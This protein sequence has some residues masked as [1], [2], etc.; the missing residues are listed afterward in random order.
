MTKLIA[1]IDNSKFIIK[2]CENN[3]KHYKA[4]IAIYVENEEYPLI[5]YI[6]LSTCDY[7]YKHGLDKEWKSFKEYTCILIHECKLR[8]ID[9][10]NECN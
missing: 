8:M 2:I 9:N 4:R 6:D 1:T 5:D 3:E 7:S 10:F